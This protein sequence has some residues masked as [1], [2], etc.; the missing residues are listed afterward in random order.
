MRR[1]A[2]VSLSA[3]LVLILVWIA[4]QRRCRAHHHARQAPRSRE[5][6]LAT[7]NIQWLPWKRKSLQP[8]VKMLAHHSVIFLQECFFRWSSAVE[9]FFPEHH[10]CKGKLKGV[11]LI[12]SGLVILSKFPIVSSE[13]VPFRAYNPLS[14]DRLSEKGILSA[15]VRIDDQDVRLITTHLQSSTHEEYDLYGLT[16]LE[17]LF[18]Y[19]STVKE[20]Y[21]IGGDFNIDIHEV[22]RRYPAL[23]T[24]A[25]T[26]PTIY[27]NFHSGDTQATPRKGF[28]GRVLDYFIS[29]MIVCAPPRVQTSTYSDHNPVQTM[30]SLFAAP[31]KQEEHHQQQ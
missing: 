17:E 10:V 18:A 13:F 29:P 5:C 25:P 21:I 1:W 4:S 7:Y 20:P 12:N 15:V 26:E 28:E 16:Q 8:L 14:F 27:I 23:Q 19:A 31:H 3:L 22:R 30:I 24:Y 2:T 9:T 6:T 11:R